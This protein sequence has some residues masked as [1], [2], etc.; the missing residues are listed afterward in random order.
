MASRPTALAMTFT[1]YS[2]N[3]GRLSRMSK[4]N[5]LLAGAG[6]LVLAIV[7]YQIPAINS[8]VAWRY[9]VGK[10]FVR[11]V[12][13]PVGDVP[14]AIPGTPNPTSLASPT[15]QVVATPTP[16]FGLQPSET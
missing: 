6:L 4:R 14:T 9:E 2:S 11:N 10:T 5:I 8:R 13:N 3:S 7:L 15:S 1:L 16:S 12:L